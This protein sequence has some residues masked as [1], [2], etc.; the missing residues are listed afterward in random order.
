MTVPGITL[1][2]L[3]KETPDPVFPLPHP[4]HTDSK[5]VSYAFALI[6]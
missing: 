1:T 2:K 6:L 5:K 3:K 4:Q